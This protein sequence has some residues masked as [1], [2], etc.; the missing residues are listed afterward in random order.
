MSKTPQ[1]TVVK[2]QGMALDNFAIIAGCNC[3]NF[4]TGTGTYKSTTAITDCEKRKKEVK[5]AYE[6]GTS[7][8]I[9]G[10]E[11]KCLIRSGIVRRA[12]QY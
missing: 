9:K 2:S 1:K 10:C 4:F 6:N 8:E 7:I 12:N 5:E 3:T 11:S